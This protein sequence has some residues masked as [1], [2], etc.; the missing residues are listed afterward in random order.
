MDQPVSLYQVRQP[1]L[2]FPD[3]VHVVRV[4]GARR[5]PSRAGE[6]DAGG[7]GIVARA[8]DDDLKETIWLRGRAT[9]NLAFGA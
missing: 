9:L 2:D 4:R 5:P 7:Y 3:G 8:V 1:G 6:G